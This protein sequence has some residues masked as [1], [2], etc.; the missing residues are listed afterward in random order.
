MVEVRSS[1]L[2]VPTIECI[3]SSQSRA[4]AFSPGLTN[5][6]PLVTK[7]EKF[8]RTQSSSKNAIRASIKLSFRD[9]KGSEKFN[10]SFA[11]SAEYPMD[12]ELEKN[13]YQSHR[14]LPELLLN[15][16]VVA[17][18]PLQHSAVPRSGRRPHQAVAAD[19]LPDSANRPPQTGRQKSGHCRREPGRSSRRSSGADARSLLAKPRS[20]SR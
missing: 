5:S 2:L 3:E 17:L 13:N 16:V 19:L 4:V 11:H 18:G 1:S 15:V 7:P 8:S 12:S 20:L 10:G 14:F 9:R 6:S